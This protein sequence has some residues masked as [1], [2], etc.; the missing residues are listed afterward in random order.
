MYKFIGGTFLFLSA[1]SCQAD[2]YYEEIDATYSVPL[3]T[4]SPYYAD[5]SMGILNAKKTRN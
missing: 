5:I 4:Y 1:L 2:I 3:M